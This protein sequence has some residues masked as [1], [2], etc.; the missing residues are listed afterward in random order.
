MNSGAS[1][2][3]AARRGFTLIEILVAIL[4]I[5]ALMGL[6]IG[7]IHHALRTA[8]STS[9][10]AAVKAIQQGVSQ[11]GQTMSFVPPLVKDG[12][13]VTNGG[14]GPLNAARTNPV[15]YSFA[16]TPLTNPDATVLL[17]NV[18]VFSQMPGP[19]GGVG[20]TDP[21][22]SIYSLAYYVMGALERPIDGV[23]GPGFRMV[24]R[25]G[26]FEKSGRQLGPFF[27]PRRAAAVFEESPTGFGRI[28]LR[29]SHDV[30]FRY[31]RW[32]PNSALANPPA[33]PQNQPFFG[34]NIP[35]LVGDP[36]QTPELRN[37]Q[38][39]I[40]GAGPNG[41]FGDEDLL[42]ANHPQWRSFDNLASAV[43]ISVSATPTA[44]D[45]LKVR[46]AAA[47]DNVVAVGAIR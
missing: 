24:R 3:G 11:F 4:V 25:D 26:S 15:V 41:V 6:L 31:Y 32:L 17:S 16:A 36:S 7:G 39:A 34:L 29:D 18:A 37:A 20:T 28:Q 45:V 23:D 38:Y 42:P 1:R 13:F 2:A 27:D 21:R 35:E 46:K 14:L 43:G 47:A 5:F 22:F 19:A 44:A 30:A 40:V 33:N 10:L 9:D 8:K 12:V